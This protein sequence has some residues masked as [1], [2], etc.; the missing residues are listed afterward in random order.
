M[1]RMLFMGYSTRDIARDVGVTAPTVVNVKKDFVR[2]AERVGLMQGANRYG[3]AKQVN[4]LIDLAKNVAGLR[5]GFS[6]IESG[7]EYGK[8]FEKVNVD[9]KDVSRFIDKVY[10]SALEEDLKPN[11]IGSLLLRFSEVSEESELG[12]KDAV[13]AMEDASERRSADES[14]VHELEAEIRGLEEKKVNANDFAG[15]A[16]ARCSL[17]EKQLE[18]YSATLQKLKGKVS[19]D[20]V[21]ALSHV[22]DRM[23]GEGK[24]Y[25]EVIAFYGRDV[26]LDAERD[27]KVRE[28]DSLKQKKQGLTANVEKT[29]ASLESDRA[30]LQLIENWKLA[31]LSPDRGTALMGKVEELGAGNGLSREEAIDRF[32]AD[33]R[34]H[35]EPLLGFTNEHSRVSAKVESSKLELDNLRESLKVTKQAYDSTIAAVR[36]KEALN[37][38]GVGD[39]EIVAWDGVLTECGTD[40]VSFRGEMTKLGG[41]KRLVGDRRSEVKKAEKQLSDLYSKIFIEEETYNKFRAANEAFG[42]HFEKVVQPYLYRIEEKMADIEAK[43]L[44]E[45]VGIEPRMES[46]VKDATTDFKKAVNLKIGEISSE[47]NTLVEDAKKGQAN[48]DKGVKVSIERVDKSIASWKRDRDESL[49]R[50]YELG[51]EVQ[52]YKNLSDMMKVV[53]GELP[54]SIDFALAFITFLDATG[55]YYGRLNYPEISADVNRLKDKMMREMRDGR[56]ST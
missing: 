29:T 3:V 42:E 31:G 6:T 47:M 26:E 38:R 48:F 24:P 51:V 15:K 27:E 25:E 19:F 20:D 12:F 11:D 22:V 7:V 56:L 23:V 32:H 18:E 21:V 8:S 9:P 34:E 28:I 2:T 52:K 14:R 45:E 40:L 54:Q 17:T 53:N 50:I 49:G 30:T 43:L 13:R 4:N 36:A 35:W 16:L 5:G 55:K 1:L 39:D 10:D 46:A 41:I 44:D 37:K 33:L